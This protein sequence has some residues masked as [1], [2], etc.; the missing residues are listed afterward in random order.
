[1]IEG[2][3]SRS[4]NSCAGSSV[5]PSRPPKRQPSRVTPHDQPRCATP[6]PSGAG[7]RRARHEPASAQMK[8]GTSG[9]FELALAAQPV[10]DLVEAALFE[11]DEARALGDL[12]MTG[13]A[14]RRLGLS[15][16]R[17]LTGALCGIG[18]HDDSPL[19]KSIRWVQAASQRRAF[20]TAGSAAFAR[21]NGRART[22]TLA[23]WATFVINSP[24]A[25]ARPVRALRAGL[26]R[27]VN[28][29]R[30]PIQPSELTIASAAAP[31]SG[32]LSLNAD[33]GG[34]SALTG[35]RALGHGCERPRRPRRTHAFA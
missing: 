1:M 23:G 14:G 26:T 34:A 32:V 31:P 25:G 13:L 21:D 24:V 16:V 17:S 5:T 7:S 18:G 6:R 2:A 12:V 8:R 19:S 30:P 29:T 27:T 33:E 4:R 20:C 35:G 28:W 3:P 15:R 22:S 9:R 11:V 10:S